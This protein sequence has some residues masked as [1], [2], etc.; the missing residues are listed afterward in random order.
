MG[1]LPGEKSTISIKQL[2]LLVK[3]LLAKMGYYTN[4]LNYPLSNWFEL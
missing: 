1:S 2:L 4:I 3:R